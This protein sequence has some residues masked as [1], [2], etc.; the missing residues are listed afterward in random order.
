MS[1]LIEIKN[2]EVTIKQ[3]GCRVVRGIDFSLGEGESLILLG[4]SGCGK[5]MTCHSIMGLLDPRK[6]IVSG[7]IIYGGRDILT[8]TGRERR[9]LYGGEIA[10]V[11]QNPMTALDPSM[12]IGKQMLETLLLHRVMSKKEGKNVV[13]EAIEG[14]GLKDCQRVFYSYPFEL[15]GGMLQRVLIA[16]VLMVRARLVIADEPTTALDVVNRNETIAAFTQL[17]ERGTGVLM[18]THDFAA[19]VQLGGKIVI[20]NEGEIVEEGA[21]SD[22]LC[23]PQH[24]YTK[25]LIEASVLN[26]KGRVV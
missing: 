26:S 11:P 10:F 20:M 24:S 6:F 9:K 25:N 18:V 2:L 17:R 15:S 23:L 8:L 1:T 4:Q 7:Q 12:R 22:I 14:A 3:E 19:A 16:M 21:A 13:L 5:T